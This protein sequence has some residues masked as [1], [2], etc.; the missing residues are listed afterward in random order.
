MNPSNIKDPET[1]Y[2]LIA[3]VVDVGREDFFEKAKKIEDPHEE[4]KKK[5]DRESGI[6]VAELGIPGIAVERLSWRWYPGER[7]ASHTL[8]IIGYGSD[9]IIAGRYG[10]ERYYEDVL[11]R[12]NEG[13]SK[14]LFVELLLGIKNRNIENREGDIVTTIEPSAQRYLE[15]VI[16]ETKKLWSADSIGGI[17]MDPKTGAIVAMSALPDFNPNDR[18]VSDPKVFSNPLVENVYEMGS[19]IKPLTVAMGIDSNAINKEDT[20]EDTGSVVLN[21]KRISNYDGRA[22]GRVVIQE[23]LS[24]SLNVGIAHIITTMGRNTAKEYFQ[25][26]GFGEKTGID[27][28]N[29]EMGIVKNINSNRDIELAT[30]GY[31]QGIAV[32]PISTVRALS[33]L[34]NG[35]LIVR[36]YIASHVLGV[37]GIVREL[38]KGESRRVFKEETVKDVTDML[39]K[40]FD[41]AL[42]NGDFMMPR[43]QIA[44]KTGT[45]Q[46]ADPENGGYYSDRYLHSFFGYFPASDPRFIVFLY[47]IYPKGA[48]YASETLAS[49]FVDITK[50]LINYYEI[51]PDR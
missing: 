51:P 44:A 23:I 28:P 47:Q 35:G 20:Y 38:E 37:D 39:V 41:T 26:L 27:Q 40:V 49:P 30:A 11:R 19:I 45:A 2:E 48:D 9:D 32:T 31:G 7:L 10:L 5:L 13:E 46:I 29:E 18:D 8:G 21:S 15:E 42:R 1:A 33:S 34:A 3:Q 14:N 25:N 12:H 43:Y 4:L 36:P 16:N 17:I 22:R 6:A 50:F 24:Q